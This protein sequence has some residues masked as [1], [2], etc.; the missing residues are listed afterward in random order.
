MD[1]RTPVI[2]G[3][4]QLTD[5]TTPADAALSPRGLM[6]AAAR[7]A[8]ADA[9]IAAAALAA[10]DSITV[11]R[12][13]SDTVPSM[14]SPFGAMTNAPWSVA[15]QLGATP[16][17]LVYPPQGGDTPQT[18]LSRA[19]TRIAAGES[20]LALVVG[21]EALRTELAA[22]RAGLALDWQEDAP[23]PPEEL[24][25]ASRLFTPAE[26]AH[27]MRS[28]ICMYALFEQAI[29]AARGETAEQRRTALGAMFARFALVA[30]D[31]PLATR[32]EG[33]DAAA[34]TAVTKANPT[35]GF[36]YTKLM[37]ANMYVDQA[38]ALLV[39]STAQAD[40]LGVPRERRVYLHASAGAHDSWFVTERAALH[41]SP[42][43]RG[44]VAATFAAAG[45]GLDDIAAFDIYSCFPSAVQVAC[46]E[47]GLAVDDPRGLTVTGGLS[48]FGGPGNNYITHAIAEMVQR[49]RAMPARHGLVTANGGLLTKHATGLYS[50]LPPRQPFAECDT[51][52][53][54]AEIEALPKR[55][56]AAQPS[57]RGVVESWTVV[58]GRNGPERGIVLGRLLASG[59]RFIANTPNDAATLARLEREDALGLP[60]I[61]APGAPAN[62]FTPD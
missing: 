58:N 28:A 49:L 6:V 23:A 44:V 2:I 36:P 16:Q 57:G 53:L 20:E 32:R 11:I 18:M 12:L 29:R 56:P 60:G 25:G 45:V 30:R 62:L 7:L 52:A 42:A 4:G 39:A 51:T 43:I 17:D 31:N 40:A 48:F 14:R 46:D 5:T 38:A 13:F 41:R 15:R 3:V 50:A 8:A 47:I 10:L 26:E 27:G 9:G 22:R 54:Q 59:E 55:L 34:I 33:F 1:P 19:C 61:V 24:G 37:T 35:V 21:A